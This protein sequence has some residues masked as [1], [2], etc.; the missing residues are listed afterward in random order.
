MRLIKLAVIS[1]VVL[2]AVAAFIGALLPSTVLVSRAVNIHVPA[3]SVLKY[4]SDIREWKN[5][6]EG[7][8]DTTMM[9]SSPRNAVLGNT[10]VAITG[11]SDSAVLSTWETRNGTIQQ[12]TINI[13]P[14]PGEVTIVQWQFVQKLK[15]YPWEKLGSMMNDKIMGT[16]ME[17]NLSRL[18]DY[19]EASR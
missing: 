14:G 4:T 5:W 9:V 15:W 17:K 19:L 7:L 10:A 6:I 18:R 3:D 11:V 8:N 2:F 16:M 12:S 1:V 13:I